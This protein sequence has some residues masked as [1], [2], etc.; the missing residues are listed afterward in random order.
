MDESRLKRN[1]LTFRNRNKMRYNVQ[2]NNRF[3]RRDMTLEDS[4]ENDI[5]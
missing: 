4:E 3:L 5:S 1:H 2:Y